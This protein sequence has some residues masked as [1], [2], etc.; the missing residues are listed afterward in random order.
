MVSVLNKNLMTLKSEYLF[1]GSE[2]VID[3]VVEFFLG[4]LNKTVFT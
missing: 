4:I 1:V 2:N 3:I